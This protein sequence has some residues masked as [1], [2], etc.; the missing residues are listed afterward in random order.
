MERALCPVLIGREAQL[1]VLE[2]RLS[3]AR[4][5]EGQVVVLVGESGLGKTRLV[6]ELQDSALRMGCAVM[7]GACPRAEFSLPYLPYLEAIGNYL[8]RADIESVRKSLGAARKD[9]ATLFPQIDPEPPALDPGDTGQSKTRLFESVLALLAV[10]S[11]DRSLLLVIE[12]AHWSDPST[13]ELTDYLTRRM[14]G[15][16]VLLVVTCRSE[17][18]HRR[19]PMYVVIEAWRRSAT[20][21]LVEVEAL[22]PDRMGAMASS[23]LNLPPPPDDVRD[24][25]HSRTEGSP[26]VLEEMLKSA[27]DAGQLAGEQGSWDRDAL[28]KMA[29]PKTVRDSIL[30]RLDGLQDVSAEVVRAAAVLGDSFAYETLVGLT[31]QSEPAVQEA[32]EACVSSQLL[33]EDHESP[34]LYRFRHALTKEAVYDDLIGPK[35]LQLHARAAEVLAAAGD[36]RWV[37][38]CQ[39][40]VAAG[41]WG[42][43]VPLCLK[44]AEEATRTYA[45]RDAI[46]LYQRALPYVRLAPERGRTLGHLGVAHLMN[47]EPGKAQQALEDAVALLEEAGETKLAAHYRLS[48]GKACWQHSDIDAARLHFDRARA[49]LEAD[50]A[51]EDLAMAYVQMASMAVVDLQAEETVRLARRASEIAKECGAAAAR[52]WAYNFMGA[53]LALQG[54]LDEGL[55]YLD[56]SYLEAFQLGL[57]AVAAEALFAAVL[58]RIL[59]HRGLEALERVSLLRALGE[60]GWNPIEA[61]MGEGMVY[62]LVFGEPEKALQAFDRAL[63]PARA[64]EAATWLGWAE[65]NRAIAFGQLARQDRARRLLQV[66]NMGQEPHVRMLHAWAWMRTASDAGVPQTALPIAQLVSGLRDGPPAVLRILWDAAVAVLLAV[67]EEDM[68][69]ELVDIVSRQADPQGLPHQKR[70]EGR[71]ALARGDLASA[72]AALGESV[73]LW[74]GA[75]AWHEEARTRLDLAAALARDG[76]TDEAATELRTVISAA[77]RRGAVFEAR[78]A[79]KALE[80]LGVSTVASPKQVEQALIALDRPDELAR[81]P[82]AD[83]KLLVETALTTGPSLRDLIVKAVQDLAAS[84]DRVEAQAGTLLRDYYVRRIGTHEVI[85]ARMHMSRQNYFRRRKAAL[86]LLAQQL[87]ELEVPATA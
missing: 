80:G 28:F 7:S 34:G 75:A 43:A 65:I 77:G 10:A 79:R 20:A 29:L 21:T 17:E 42:E 68:A 49:T 58:W 18:L 87:G 1:A 55:A 56:Q 11:R 36:V 63:L 70:M 38:L 67:G 33:T 54:Q 3:A 64:G 69:G 9:L 16:P 66:Q 82:L 27:I 60:A 46:A 6:K 61:A 5:G 78:S 51:S 48:L 44:A 45:Y 71:M 47:G 76:A 52:A 14:R 37:D 41:K 72:R 50:G 85:A 25:L 31:G 23:T 86:A 39:Q 19:N 62:S 32:L 2:D 35:R 57:K 73:S 81:S 24:F 84:K 13:R 83:L 12:D 40:L 8:S 15:H 74:H 4:Q 53:G 30:L 59:G 22:S 26:F